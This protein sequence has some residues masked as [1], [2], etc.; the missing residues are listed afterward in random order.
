MQ[1][2]HTKSIP[3][4][5]LT[6]DTLPILLAITVLLGFIALGLLS[7]WANSTD[8]WAYLIVPGTLLLASIGCNRMR[9]RGNLRQAAA[10]LAY[11]YALP[12]IL[13][14]LFFGLNNNPLICLSVIGVLIAAI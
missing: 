5:T 8:I 13:T 10:I 4:E 7:L 11:A 3:D 12:P 1:R 9:R 14:A 2:T 6:A